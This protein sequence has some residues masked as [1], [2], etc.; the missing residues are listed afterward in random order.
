YLVDEKT[1]LLGQVPIE[2]LLA[3]SPDQRLDEL[4]GAPP[5]EVGPETNAE[6]VALLAVE[7]HGADV[8][9]VDAQ[10]KLL[11]AIP[12]GRLLP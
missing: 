10:R 7:R 2:T 3:A 11:G 1:R 8:T 12:I 6:T 4:R 9:V 5:L